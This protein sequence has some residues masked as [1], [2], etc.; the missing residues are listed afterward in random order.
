METIFDKFDKEN[1]SGLERVLFEGR[2]EV[3]QSEYEAEKAVAYL[4]SQPILGFDTETKPQFQKGH[5]SLVA[6]LQVSSREVCFLFRLNVIGLPK[7]LIQLLSDEGE[8]IKVGLSW[9]DDLFGLQ[10]R[11]NFMPGPFIEIQQIAKEMGLKDLSLQKL[12]ANLL[13]GRISKAQRLSNWEA[14]ILSDAQKQY[15]ATDAWAC[16]QL[17]ER[18]MQLRS[19]GY[20]LQ[21]MPVSDPVKSINF[22]LEGTTE[23]KTS[24]EKENPKPQRT[25]KSRVSAKSKRTESAKDEMTETTEQNG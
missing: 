11:E 3:V 2:I 13:G 20:L 5:S 14:D 19:A 15:A 22:V 4:L 17:Y 8:T 25:R 7:C 24:A 10:R 1:I 12:Y 23:S 6:L 18:M 21:V 9:R 16:I